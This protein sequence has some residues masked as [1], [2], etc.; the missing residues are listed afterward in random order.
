MPREAATGESSTAAGDPCQDLVKEYE[1]LQAVVMMLTAEL[2]EAERL[3]EGARVDRL[4]LKKVLAVNQRSEVFKALRKCRDAMPGTVGLRERPSDDRR[5]SREEAAGS[6][7]K[8]S[9]DG[10]ELLVPTHRPIPGEAREE[11]GSKHTRV[12]PVTEP[13][14]AADERAS[15][16][17]PDEVFERARVSTPDEVF[18]QVIG[19]TQARGIESSWRWS[20]PAHRDGIQGIESSRRWSA[21]ALT[22]RRIR[23]S[24]RRIAS[25]ALV[26]AFVLGGLTAFIL[27]PGGGKTTSRTA[28]G[29]SALSSDGRS[30]RPGLGAPSVSTSQ[31]IGTTPST[32]APET[33]A[34]GAGSNATSET[35]L[36]TSPPGTSGAA[37]TTA[38]PKTSGNPG[39]P[40]GTGQSTTTS[41]HPPD[42]VTISASPQFLSSDGST[43]TISVRVTTSSGTPVSGAPLTFTVSGASCGSV[44]PGSVVAQNGGGGTTYTAAGSGQDC[45]ITVNESREVQS[46]SSWWTTWSSASVMV[47]N[48]GVQ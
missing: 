19:R 6:P 42:K 39:T 9:A 5:T 4:I 7:S 3:D 14:D 17:T 20:A 2:I 44:S 48:Q 32:I 43:S 41:S 11:L 28:A 8:T 30:A 12:D 24:W 21:P 23:A 27:F 38:P 22:T 15:L 47:V 16:D 36:P 10:P 1:R 33:G 37:P 13:P 35:S 40:S 45:T 18:E 46:G 29:H 31:S 25:V 26:A 34:G